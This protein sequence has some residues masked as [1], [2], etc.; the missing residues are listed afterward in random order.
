MPIC[1]LF[2]C[3]AVGWIIKPQNAIAEIESEGT[4]MAP[5][6]KGFYSVMIRYITPVLIIVVEIGGLASE[7]KAGNIA[8]VVFAYALIAV[9]AAVYFAFLRNSYTGTN[10]D[11]KLK[12]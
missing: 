7:I 10:A 6:L 4:P 1:A 5:W 9:C 2:A 11:E 12:K 8:V 3:L